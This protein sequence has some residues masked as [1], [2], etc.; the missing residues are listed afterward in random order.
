VAEQ[1]LQAGVQIGWNTRIVPFGPYSSSAIFALGFANRAGHGLR[2]RAAGRYKRCC[3]TT[4]PHL[5]LRE[6]P[7]RSRHRLGRGRGRLRQ[8]G[9]PTI[10]DTDIPEVLPTGI[11]TY[12]HV[13]ANVAHADMVQKSVE[14]RGLKVQ[15]ATIDIPCPSARLT[16]ASACAARISTARWAVARLSAPSSVKW[17]R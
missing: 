9:F 8:L 10:A 7:G 17:P 2:R 13:V 16:R 3:F 15:V 12:E 5:R 11:C 4:R 1:L 6:R 14:V